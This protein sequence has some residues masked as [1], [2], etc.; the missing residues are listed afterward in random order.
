MIY[1][2]EDQIQENKLKLLE[3]SINQLPKG[4]KV[5]STSNLNIN[6]LLDVLRPWECFWEY[7]ESNPNSVS[8]KKEGLV[9]K[10]D[11]IIKQHEIYNLKNLKLNV[12]NKS[13]INAKIKEIETVLKKMRLTPSKNLDRS[14]IKYDC[15]IYNLLAEEYSN[16]DLY[17]ARKYIALNQHHQN[18][19]DKMWSTLT[20]NGKLDFVR[21]SIVNEEIDI[22]EVYEFLPKI[23]RKEFKIFKGE[24]IDN[25]S[26]ILLSSMYVAP[27]NNSVIDLEINRKE[28]INLDAE[29]LIDLTNIIFKEFQ[30]GERLQGKEIKSRLKD[31][32]DKYGINK[33][34]R[35]IDLG[36]YFD[37][38][39]TFSRIKARG[40]RL[41]SRKSK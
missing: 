38:K 15:D 12:L 25:K 27:V 2:I 34:P 3:C 40:Y 14:G 32:Y 7:K 23:I 29:D 18:F 9:D 13:D 39:P 5:I 26:E 30:I 22:E 33:S 10:I 21:N 8:Y 11:S 17:Y 19:L 41:S 31:I 37:I 4:T 24:I 35:I 1:V 20:D 16:D 6:Q 36:E 28:K